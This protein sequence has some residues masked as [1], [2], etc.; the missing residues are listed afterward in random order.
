MHL[1][2]FLK[3]R[4]AESYGVNV[5]YRLACSGELYNR[6]VQ[7]FDWRKSDATRTL[8]PSPNAQSSI[9]LF[10]TVVSY[11]FNNYPQELSV[12]LTLNQC[13]EE[14]SDGLLKS[15]RTFLPDEDVVEDLCSILSLLSRRLISPV[16]KTRELHRGHPFK[17]SDQIEISTP[18]IGAPNYAIWP[19]RPLTIATN[20]KGS[21]Y[22]ENDPPPVG[23][24]P[25]A[26]MQFLVQLVNR[27]NAS[28]IVQAAR[29]YRS[30]LEFI[31]SRADTAYVMLVS[32][33]ETLAS[34][35]Y[36]DFEPEMSEKLAAYG[37]LQSHAK[38]LRLD[39]TT[40]EGLVSAASKGNYW[41]KKKFLK[42]CTEYCSFDEMRTPDRTF[43]PLP[44]MIPGA[45]EVNVAL[46]KIY[47]ARSENLHQSGSFPPG[48]AVGTDTRIKLKDLPV[49]MTSQPKIPPVTWF[50]RVVSIAARKLLVPTGSMPFEETQHAL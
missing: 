46:K 24:D 15:S 26:L 42:F 43:F 39:D 8:F 34:V 6:T 36:P 9:P 38:K 41:I 22:I 4:S 1:L 49:N 21:K 17:T 29:V 48:V 40:I 19:R 12:R 18:I 27:P 11:P 31:G 3:N 20:H 10:I 28:R 32:T 14:S 13:T 2:E 47:D 45:T 5:E 25:N 23:V 30:A 35:A 37:A 33:A 16:V 7:S 50:E 44:S